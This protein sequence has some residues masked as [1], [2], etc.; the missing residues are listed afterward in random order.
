MFRT[1]YSVMVMTVAVVVGLLGR[2]VDNRRLGGE[3]HPRHRGRVEHRRAGHLD[4]VD[5][6]VGD[7]VAVAELL[8]VE[9]VTGANGQSDPKVMCPGLA[10]ASSEGSAAALEDSAVS[11]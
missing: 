8:G 1:A 10:K 4:R 2:L 3:H 11:K 7:Q 6:A 5:D 9:P